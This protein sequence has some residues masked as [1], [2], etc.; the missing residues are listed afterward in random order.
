MRTLDQANHF[1]VKHKD[2]NCIITFPKE[3]YLILHVSVPV[4]VSGSKFEHPNILIK[5]STINE[6]KHHHRTRGKFWTAKAAVKMYFAFRKKDI[7]LEQKECGFSYV[8]IRIGNEICIISCSGGTGPI[9]ALF[10]DGPVDTSFKWYDAVSQGGYLCGDGFSQKKLKTLA[11]HAMSPEECRKMGV[12]GDCQKLMNKRY[13]MELV[14]SSVVKLKE[15]MRLVIAKGY[16]LSGKPLVIERKVK[17]HWLIN[18]G[19]WNVFR[20]YRKHIDW[21]KTA[22]A[23]NIQLPSP[24]YY[25]RLDSV[26]DMFYNSPE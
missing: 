11:E 23:N 24:V 5:S 9:G 6:Y 25:N 22:K 3:D 26:E 2:E 1:V 4:A 12:T 18:E 19:G 16:S 14:A 10:A 20:V 7:I 17:Q 8:R 21:L 13:Y 15:G